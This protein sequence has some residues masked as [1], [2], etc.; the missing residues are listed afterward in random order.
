MAIRQNWWAAGALA[1]EAQISIKIWGFRSYKYQLI[2][3]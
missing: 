3:L 1:G 2:T